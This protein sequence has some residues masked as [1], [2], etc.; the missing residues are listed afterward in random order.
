MSYKYT[1]GQKYSSRNT[2]EKD[3]LTDEYLNRSFEYDSET[4]AAYQDY[5]KMMAESGQK[6]MTDTV[7]KATALTGGYANS[8]ASTAGQQVY[9]DYMQEAA[10]AK[11]DF[12]DRAYQRYAQEGADIAEQIAMLDTREADD[13]ATW[14]ADYAAD[15]ADATVRKDTAALAQIYGYESEADYLAALRQDAM[16]ALP[17]PT[18]EQLSEA[19]NMYLEKGYFEQGDA[20]DI[21]SYFEETYGVNPDKIIRHLDEM[22]SKYEYVKDREFTYVSGNGKDAIYKDQ[23]GNEFFKDELENWVKGQSG[24]EAWDELW[25]KLKGKR[26]SAKKEEE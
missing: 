12:R 23:F 5:A 17:A 15:I 22:R 18:S 4:D 2:G 9:N 24:D 21:A 1:R 10:L 25:K 20:K 3:R 16:D 13:R 8:Y 14:E 6:A 11:E 19:A 7:G 26:K